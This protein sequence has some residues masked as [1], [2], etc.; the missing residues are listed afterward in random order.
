MS[1][2]FY[3]C[4]RS[5]F[6]DIVH[7]ATDSIRKLVGLCCQ[8]KSESESYPPLQLPGTAFHKYTHLLYT[9]YYVLHGTK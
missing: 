2:A 3:C 4:I 1:A 6:S 7:I 8:I 5:Y 9:P